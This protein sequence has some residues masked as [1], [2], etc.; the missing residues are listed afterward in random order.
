MERPDDNVALSHL[1]VVE[2]HRVISGKRHMQPLVQEFPERVFGIF[3]EQ[4]VVAKRRHGNGN[5]SKVVEILQHGTL[6]NN[7][8]INVTSVEGQE[9]RGRK[10]EQMYLSDKI[11]DLGRVC[12]HLQ[13][14]PESRNLPHSHLPVNLPSPSR[15]HIFLGLS[16]P[17]LA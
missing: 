5:L 14:K 11:K 10:Q 8:Q 2:L 12:T 3:E 13:A 16:C 4:A 9:W 7:H 6:Q 15:A 1:R 17:P